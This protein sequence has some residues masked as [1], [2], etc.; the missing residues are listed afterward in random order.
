MTLHQQNKEMLSDDYFLEGHIKYLVVGNNCRLL[1][2]RRTP[3]VIRSM[4]YDSGHFRWE[5]L[6]FEDKGKTWDVT[7]ESVRNFQFVKNGLVNNEFDKI[8]AVIS[9]LDKQISIPRAVDN[10]HGTEKRI[11]GLMESTHKWIRNNSKFIHQMIELDRKNATQLE[12]ISYDF[13]AYMASVDLLSLETKTSELMVLNPNSGEWIKGLMIVMAELGLA[14]YDGKMIRSEGLFTGM[15][16][17][18]TRERYILHRMAFI[19]CLFNRFDKSHLTLFRGMS[20]ERAWF[21]PKRTFISMT[22]DYD[23][24]S[25]FSDFDENSKYQTSYI[26]KSNIDINQLFMTYLET[27]EMNERYQEKEAIIFD[28]RNMII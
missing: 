2:G 5:I 15:G 20:S 28:N 27:K 19:R 10:L 13:L 11:E 21:V 18:T 24:A 4:D 23:V 16:D 17:K 3:G 9:K 26:I 22:F 14:S 12:Q 1:D 8:E 25:E 6:D 7:F